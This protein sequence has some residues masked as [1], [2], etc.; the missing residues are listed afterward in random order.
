MKRIT[1]IVSQ[2][3]K[4][5]VGIIELLLSLP[6]LTHQLTPLTKQLIQDVH[7]PPSI[8]ITV[9]ILYQYAVY[10]ENHHVPLDELVSSFVDLGAVHFNRGGEVV[11]I[12]GDGLG[13]L[14]VDLEVVVVLNHRGLAIP[15]QEQLCAFLR[16]VM[17]VPL[18][19]EKGAGPRRVHEAVACVAL[20]VG[21]EADAGVLEFLVAPLHPGSDL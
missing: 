17:S 11:A 8:T 21:V 18:V 16:E 13:G 10:L 9:V 3:E 2:T 4:L 20:V 7:Q 1:N 6:H 19:E 12:V 5:S 15:G 14:D